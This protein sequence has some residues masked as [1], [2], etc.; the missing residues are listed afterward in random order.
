MENKKQVDWQLYIERRNAFFYVTTMN[1]AYGKYLKKETG[2]GFTDQ[3][4]V[5]KDGLVSFYKSQEELQKA[6]EHFLEMIKNNAPKLRKLHESGLECLK[7]KNKLIELF[8]DIDSDYIIKNYDRLMKRLYPIYVYHTV[9]PFTLLEAIESEQDEYAEIIEMFEIFRR[10]SLNPIH[11]L[12]LDKIWKAAAE[13]TNSEDHLDFSYFTPDELGELFKG[14]NYPGKYEIE[15]RKNA[16]VFYEQDGDI[17]FNYDSGFIEKAGI[18]S[19]DLN[20]DICN[21]TELK[22]KTVCKGQAG[23]IKGRACIINKPFEMDKFQKGDIIISINTTPDLMPVLAKSKAIVTDEGG[24]TCHAAIVSRELEKPC[25]IGTKLATRF[26]NDGDYIEVDAENGIVKKIDR[27]EEFS[28]SDYV[29][30]FAGKWS[31]FTCSYLGYFMSKVIKD[32]LGFG[33]QKFFASVKNLYSEGHYEKQ[34]LDKFGEQLS[35]MVIK[36]RSLAAKWSAQLKQEADTVRNLMENKFGKVLSSAEFREFVDCLGQYMVA[37]VFVKQVVN[38]IP[39]DILEQV[40]PCLEDARLYAEQVYVESEKFMYVL[41]DRVSK[42]TGY[43][44]SDILCITKDEYIDYA[45]TG[46]LPD[47]EILEQRYEQS[48]LVFED[49]DYDILTGKDAEK[50]KNAMHGSS[51]STLKGRSAYPGKV[52]G[53]VRVVLVP[54]PDTKFDKGD[55]L[56]SGMTRPEFLPLMEKAGAV[57]TDAGGI[58]CHAAIVARELKIPTVIGTEKATKVFNNGDTV[59]VDAEKGVVKKVK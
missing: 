36:D 33:F 23:K 54:K 57:V 56:I 25:V 37:H 12:I 22:G 46:N 19:L 30:V 59:E 24:L 58:L 47:R 21:I 39:G 51:D 13:F 34:E 26:F 20:K 10:E 29:G 15:K 55:I 32:N 2:F 18:K 45:E 35:E 43:K 50:L 7:E 28:R 52:S 44:K 9:I 41:A 38:F 53:I 49:G 17:L 40:L 6:K 5:H 31:L 48:A 3:L 8:A 14:G 4:Y 11:G 16:C 1:Q 27:F 42:K